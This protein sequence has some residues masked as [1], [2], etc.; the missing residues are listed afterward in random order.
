MIH[1]S[2]PSEDPEHIKEY[3][4]KLNK[5]MNFCV[6]DVISVAEL[7]PSEIKKFHVKNF[8]N[9]VKVLG[10]ELILFASQM[11]YLSSDPSKVCEKFSGGQKGYLAVIIFSNPSLS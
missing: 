5:T 7:E 1:E 4:A 10:H 9:Q 11:R 6:N 2:V 3:V 8:M